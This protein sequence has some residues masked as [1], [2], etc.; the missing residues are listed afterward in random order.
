MGGEWGEYGR[1]GG[2][3]V[4]AWVREKAGLCCAG[5]KS[6][7]LSSACH[8]PHRE[9]CMGPVGGWSQRE[10]AGRGVKL[11]LPGLTTHTHPAG[12]VPMMEPSR[13]RLHTAP[14]WL[15]HLVS[16]GMGHAPRAFLSYWGY[17]GPGQRKFKAQQVMS[18]EEL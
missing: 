4:S 8:D 9:Q 7:L 17:S 1:A 10:K 13:G 14:L 5:R 18:A 2:G 12:P 15:G 3:W 16:G 6:L 11:A